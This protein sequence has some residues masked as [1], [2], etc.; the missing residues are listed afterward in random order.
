[1]IHDPSGALAPMQFDAMA[2]L[3]TF[4]IWIGVGV[5]AMGVVAA[6]LSLWVTLRGKDDAPPR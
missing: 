3:V 4:W 5:V 1:M 6:L 2:V